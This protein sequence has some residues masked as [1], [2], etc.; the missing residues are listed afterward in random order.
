MEP[1]D[2]IVLG[3]AT[4]RRGEA[5]RHAPMALSEITASINFAPTLTTDIRL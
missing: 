2:E 5:K 4:A 1:A 3:L